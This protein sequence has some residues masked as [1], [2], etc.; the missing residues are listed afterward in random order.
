MR[1]NWTRDEFGN[2]ICIPSGEMPNQQVGI[3]WF[4]DNEVIKVA[5]PYK[6]GIPDDDVI[7]Y[8]NHRDFWHTLQPVTKSERQLKACAYNTYPRGRIIFFPLRKVFRVY[9]DIC[10]DTDHYK[11][12]KVLESF[13]LEDFDIEFEY[14]ENYYCAGCNPHFIDL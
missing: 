1:G 7:Q 14:D 9:S 4:I 2:I 5:V 12:I 3:F 8:G 6:E 10:I 11:M 13:E